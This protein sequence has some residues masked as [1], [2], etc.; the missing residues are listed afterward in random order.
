MKK[1]LEGE[2]EDM[3]QARYKVGDIIDDFKVLNIL[4]SNGLG[5]I[6][7]RVEHLTGQYKGMSTDIQRKN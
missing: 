1:Y 6:T 3:A 2:Q 5:L 4:G 7:Y